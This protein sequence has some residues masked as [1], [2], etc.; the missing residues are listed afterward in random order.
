MNKV[1]SSF[2][3]LEI[4]SLHL[5]YRRHYTSLIL[6]FSKAFLEDFWEMAGLDK[7]L[8]QCCLNNAWVIDI[9]WS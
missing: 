5:N 4:I 8:E 2:Q 7:D 1:H 3:F 6:C 9:G